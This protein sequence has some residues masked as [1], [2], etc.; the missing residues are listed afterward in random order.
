MS[1]R[2]CLSVVDKIGTYAGSELPM[3]LLRF[4]TW[5]RTYRSHR[6]TDRQPSLHSTARY[7]SHASELFQNAIIAKCV[8]KEIRVTRYN[9]LVRT[10][11]FT[12]H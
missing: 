12:V 1:C 4:V 11:R 7:G 10:I 2:V 3:Q 8:A 9:V 6:S 5:R